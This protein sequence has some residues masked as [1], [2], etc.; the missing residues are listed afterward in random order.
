M[1]KLHESL[2]AQTIDLSAV[3]TLDACNFMSTDAVDDMN[4]ISTILD[5]AVDDVNDTVD[6]MNKIS[7]ILD[8]AVDDVNGFSA[9][10]AV[11]QIISHDTSNSSVI[12]QSSFS[13]SISLAT[14]A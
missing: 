14:T 1:A 13:S 11:V 3:G 4:K 7:T 8:D 6:D 2:L 10:A 5:D 9:A 12:F